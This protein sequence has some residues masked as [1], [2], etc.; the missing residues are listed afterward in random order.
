MTRVQKSMHY[1]LPKWRQ[2]A[3][4]DTLFMAK[5]AEK[6]YR[7]GPHIPLWGSTPSSGLFQKS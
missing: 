2:N 6:P 4:I 7:L 1:L 3:K 5:T